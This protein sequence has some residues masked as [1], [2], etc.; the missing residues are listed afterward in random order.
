[1]RWRLIKEKHTLKTPAD[2]L[3]VP[4]SH[5][6]WI[7]IRKQNIV[8]PDHPSSCPSQ[9]RLFLQTMSLGSCNTVPGKHLL[10]L[11]LER[12]PQAQSSRDRKNT[13]IHSECGLLH[14]F[15]LK[16][17]EMMTHTHDIPHDDETQFKV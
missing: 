11:P 10:L 14:Q 12:A 1:M 3:S 2:H 4:S 17:K 8:V 6:C 5:I 15:P 7:R 16:V 9:R 13:I